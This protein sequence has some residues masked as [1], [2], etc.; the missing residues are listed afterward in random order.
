[1]GNG[2]KYDMERTTHRCSNGR[3]AGSCNHSVGVRTMSLGP[4]F[5]LVF[6]RI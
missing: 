6:K 1:M 2:K 4:V 3:T 5:A